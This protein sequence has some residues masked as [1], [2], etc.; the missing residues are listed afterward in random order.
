MS[1]TARF[2][3]I[4]LLLTTVLVL[5]WIALNLIRPASVPVTAKIGTEFPAPAPLTANYLVAAHSL[6][7][8]TLARDDDFI[9]KAMAVNPNEGFM[10]TPE[11]RGSL[12]GSLIRNFMDT[13]API[14]AADVLRP[15]D[16]GF[17]ASVLRDGYRAVS[18]G[19]DPIS[20]VA[21]MIWP[22]DHVDILLTQDMGEKQ[23]A[24]RALS[25]TALRDVRVI[26]ID[27]EMV[28]GATSNNAIAGKLVHTVTL[29]VDPS[30]AQ[31]IA[32]AASMG[33]LSLSIRSATGNTDELAMV[34]TFGADVSPALAAQNKK[35][36]KSLMIY[37][38]VTPKEVFVQ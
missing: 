28:Q 4:G 16:R 24:H 3:I 32:A 29:E 27:Q 33:R 15:R 37:S 5:G 10:D 7:A 9:A 18:V 11:S 6:P 1:S 31:T 19:V 12:R 8:G 38:G 26:A 25:E 22:G 30:Q 14:T 35:P 36:G 21:G 2:G 13:G 17:I 23:V 20:G 34:P